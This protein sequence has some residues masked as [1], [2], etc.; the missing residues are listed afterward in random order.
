MARR[1]TLSLFLILALSF[2]AGTSWWVS[3]HKSVPGLT[4]DQ[5]TP[6]GEAQTSGRSTGS[7]V[8]QRF[9]VSSLEA[10]Q[11]AVAAD[12]GMVL[13]PAGSPAVGARVSMFSLGDMS[14]ELVLVTDAGGAFPLGGAS[15]GN[16][17]RLRATKSGVAPA[18]LNWH[19]GD[20]P[21]PVLRLGS[22]G[23]VR[24]RVVDER[25]VGAAEFRIWRT[26]RLDNEF[27]TAAELLVGEVLPE[28]LSRDGPWDFGPDVDGYFEILGLAPG[29]GC[30]LIELA[31]G[32]TARWNELFVV[33]GDVSGP[34]TICVPDTLSVELFVYD[35]WSEQPIPDAEVEITLKGGQDR[36]FQKGETDMAGRCRIAAP[37]YGGNVVVM[38]AGYATARWPVHRPTVDYPEMRIPL[39]LQ[40]P[41]EILVLDESGAAIAGERIIAQC[42]RVTRTGRT[43]SEGLL[44]FED[45]PPGHAVDLYWL[46][47]EGT[48][49]YRRALDRDETVVIQEWTPGSGPGVYGTV[50]VPSGRL[51]SGY[52]FVIGERTPG[53]TG[54]LA[55]SSL[56]GDG[57]FAVGPLEP[58]AKLTLEVRVGQFFGDNDH[59]YSWPIEIPAEGLEFSPMLSGGVILGEVGTAGVSGGVDPVIGARVRVV[60]KPEKIHN[61]DG[62]RARMR[63]RALTDAS[64]WFFVAALAGGEYE[65]VVEFPDGQR[66]TRTCVVED[67]GHVDLGRIRPGDT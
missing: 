42:R 41:I 52:V 6:R 64:G 22:G 50:S 34:H 29:P 66:A 5:A 58:G 23:G 33:E 30:L 15:P 18:L 3:A 7:E 1:A 59:Q 8:A 10:E 14:E 26:E 31:D 9:S 20:D 27:G 4:P 24:G 13:E 21:A 35:S 49:E 56:D 32:Q 44:E 37:A 51:S 65:V 54:T 60:R 48:M 46:K 43:C 45:L 39:E 17:Y 25:G 36:P 53:R 67:M 57:G 16:R 63:A 12:R 47:P 55:I 19:A 40:E 2:L 28:R 61:T 62:S 38:A 11:V